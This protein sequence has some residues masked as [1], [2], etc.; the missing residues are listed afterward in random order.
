MHGGSNHLLLPTGLLQLAAANTSPEDAIS[1]PYFGGGVVRV[2]AC[3]SSTI[4][5][6]YPAECTPELSPRVRTML[7]D[8]GHI[9]RQ[10]AP[11]VRNALGPPLLRHAHR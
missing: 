11:S 1:D 6:L 4:N 3:T 5:A 9:G 8:V 7:L 10:F 2:E